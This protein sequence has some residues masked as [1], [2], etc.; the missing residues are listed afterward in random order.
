MSRP[1]G[2]A[3][4]N[5]MTNR[6]SLQKYPDVKSGPARPAQTGRV[7]AGTKR[8]HAGAWAGTDGANYSNQ[9]A[10]WLA[11]LHDNVLQINAN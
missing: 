6:R 9:L 8:V 7:K 5:K 3:D 1:T 4:A 11:L 10:G 2:G